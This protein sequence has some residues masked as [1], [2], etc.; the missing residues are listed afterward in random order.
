M[1]TI[2]ALGAV[3]GLIVAIVLIMRKD[4]PAYSLI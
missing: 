1:A 3:I 2:T 4:N